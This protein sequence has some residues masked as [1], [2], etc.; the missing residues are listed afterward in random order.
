MDVADVAVS[1]SETRP[2]MDA[3]R[4]PQCF[5]SRCEGLREVAQGRVRL[6]APRAEAHLDREHEAELLPVPIQR[7]EQRESHA[8]LPYRLRNASQ[9]PAGVSHQ[10]LGVAS[11]SQVTGAGALECF[12]CP[13]EG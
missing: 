7:L 12:A 1:D 9:I 8:I 10:E 4:C 5:A 3:G 13:I 11:C 6:R 2:V